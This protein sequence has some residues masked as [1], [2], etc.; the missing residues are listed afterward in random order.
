MLPEL[1]GANHGRDTPISSLASIIR[2]DHAD[3]DT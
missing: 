1:T 3:H 2:I